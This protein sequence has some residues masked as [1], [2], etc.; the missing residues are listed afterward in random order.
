MPVR[1]LCF[2]PRRFSLMLLWRLLIRDPLLNVNRNISRNWNNYPHFLILLVMIAPSR[3]IVD[4]NRFKYWNLFL[5]LKVSICYIVFFFSFLFSQ[6]TGCS[7]CG[8]VFVSSIHKTFKRIKRVDISVRNIRK[9][10][11]FKYWGGK[12][13][14]QVF[15][16]DI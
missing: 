13:Q 14:L 2:L 11:I 10:R 4:W 12:Q 3:K 1:L 7:C 8:N 6:I 5:F 15:L 9:K 16:N